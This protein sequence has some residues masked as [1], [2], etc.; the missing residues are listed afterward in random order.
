MIEA[1]TAF[2][3]WWIWKNHGATPLFWIYAFVTS[4]LMVASC[5]DLDYYIIPD[6]FTLGG[7]LAGFAISM[8]YPQLHDHAISWPVSN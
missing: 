8:L 5:I 7:C 2:L 1:L 6:R 4:S 3:F